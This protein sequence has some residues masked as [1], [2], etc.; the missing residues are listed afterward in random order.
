MTLSPWRVASQRMS[1]FSDM[2]LTPDIRPS[3]NP[4]PG[5]LGIAPEDGALLEGGHYTAF[6][7]SEAGGGFVGK[8][9]RDPVFPGTERGNPEPSGQKQGSLEFEEVDEV[10]GSA[11]GLPAVRILEIGLA[12]VGVGDPQGG[13]GDQKAVDNPKSDHLGIA[14]QYAEIAVRLLHF[15][16]VDQEKTYPL[17]GADVE[18]V[19]E[20]QQGVDAK[21]AEFEKRR[22]EGVGF[23]TET[24]QTP[25]VAAEPDMSAVVSGHREKSIAREP[26]DAR[27]APVLLGV[28]V[29]IQGASI[30]CRPDV[31]AGV[32]VELVDLEHARE[33]GPVFFS[34]LCRA[35][36]G[37]CAGKGQGDGEG[38][39]FRNRCHWLASTWCSAGRP[40]GTRRRRDCLPT[41]ASGRW[42]ARPSP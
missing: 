32:D 13:S 17:L 14:P 25:P 42:P 23:G 28:D 38:T 29:E 18:P 27:E 9:E 30:G 39:K 20:C 15:L 4:L 41:P 31:A 3:P 10:L 12:E 36:S 26:V 7:D 11:E 37:W 8:L 19:A 24:A 6:E 1:A 5:T 21:I 34:V 16:L 22:I 2:S 35:G 40:Q 33:S